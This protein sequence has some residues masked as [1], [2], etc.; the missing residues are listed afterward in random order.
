MQLTKHF[1]LEEFTQSDTAD[2]LRIDNTIPEQFV[3]NV[4]I[5]CKRIL[6]PLREHLGHPIFITSGYR[7]PRLNKAVG[8]VPGSQHLRGEAADL[9][10]HSPEEGEEMVK[11]IIQHCSFDQLLYEHKRATTWLHVSN[12]I[13]RSLNRRMV[14]NIVG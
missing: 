4:F 3:P 6:E 7:C 9:Y 11:F 8:G 5:L 12:R 2:R 13:D 1:S 10:I 14:K